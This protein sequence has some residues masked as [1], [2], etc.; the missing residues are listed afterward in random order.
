MIQPYEKKLTIKQA[1]IF[2]FLIIGSITASSQTVSVYQT[3]KDETQT[4]DPRP[5]RYMGNI[6]NGGRIITIDGDVEYQT[7]D[8]FGASMTGSSAYLINK[9]MNSVQRESV[10]NSLFTSSGI[11]LSFIRHSIGSSD[12]SLFNY[13]YH[14][15]GDEFSTDVDDE[16]VIPMLQLAK[17]KNNELKILGTPWSAP[18]WMKDNFSMMGGS[19]KNDH[20]DDYALYLVRY[21]KEFAQKGLPIYAITMQNEPLH[22]TTQYPSMKMEWYQQSN[23][24]RYDLGPLMAQEN[25]NT[26]V[27][28]YD[29]NW[30][31]T[32]YARDILN[33]SQTA[34]YTAGTAFHGYAGTFNAQ[35]T[36]YNY[37]QSKGIWFTEV[38][39]TDQY[40]NF[41]DN[42]KWLATNLL[43]G[44]IRNWSKSILL[45]NL[46]LDNNNGPKNGGCNDCRG[47]VTVN[48][49]GTFD[50]EVEYYALGHLSKFVNPGAKRVK[51][52][53]NN[54]IKN[55]AF[56]NPDG[57]FVLVA[58]NTSSSYRFFKVRSGGKQFSYGLVGGALVT[59]KWYPSTNSRL[60][61]DVE[62]EELFN[63][64][65]EGFIYPSPISDWAT[66]DIGSFETDKATFTLVDLK[67][68]VVYE[69]HL[70]DQ[71]TK[72][73]LKGSFESGVYIAYLDGENFSTKMRII[74]K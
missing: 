46:A 73:D 36:V 32:D 48:S 38:T 3:T 30:D 64:H 56:K 12:F 53:N 2:I 18:A 8:G 9:K 44:S 34:V 23:L 1:G 39:G 70:T 27:L 22:T 55:V 69:H 57:S 68:Q 59:F 62:S 54:I 41:G 10:M 65:S 67:G 5:N 74:I 31:V 26:K 51:S 58:F 42:L 20:Y 60:A 21:M 11:N 43:V 33:I 63:E 29:H 25:L 28:L 7:M 40:S 15:P 16:D 52:N 72:I 17:N 47:V 71:V 35:S 66:I 19:L 14:D 6:S 50:E 61:T 37:N 13:T 24:L 4:L 45:W 49:N